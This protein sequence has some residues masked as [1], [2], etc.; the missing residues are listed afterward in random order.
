[1]I[2]RIDLSNPDLS[3]LSG[4]LKM[5]GR[6]PQGV[7]IYANNRY[8]TFGGRPWLPV[9]GEFHFSRFPNQ[10]WRDELLKM[11]AG[12]VQI[13]ASYLFWIHH[14]EIEGTFAWSGDFDYRRFIGLCA[15]LGMYVYPRIGPWAHGECRN[16][17]FPDWVL[18]KCGAGVRQDTQPYLSY[19]ERWYRQIARQ[20][21]G[22]LWK[23]GG[24]II[25]IQLE[26]ELIDNGPHILTLKRMAQD[27]GIDVP[28]YTMT[29][30]GPAQVPQDE[31]IPLFGGYPDAFWDRQVK[32]YARQSRFLYLFTPIRNDDMIGNDLL[33]RRDLDDLSYLDRYP[34][35][36]C[37]LGGGMQVSYHRRPFIT[38]GDAS[39]PPVC[40][41]GSG[42][43]LLGYYMYHG[44]SN[45]LGKLSTLQESQATHYWNDVPVISYDFQTVI[46]EYGQL[47]EQY[48]SLRLLHQFLHDFGSQLAPMPAAYPEQVPA[49]LDDRETLRWS[50]RS[51]GS[52][53]FVFINNYQR[54]ESL[55][56][57]TG[58]RLELKL[59]NETLTMPSAPFNLRSG[60]LMIW[61]FNLELGGLRL[62]YAT[63]QLVCRIDDQGT[64]CFVFAE[65]GGVRAEFALDSHGLAAVLGLEPAGSE[66]GMTLLRGLPYA[67]P[68]TLLDSQG[69]QVRI[70]LLSEEQSEQCWKAQIWGAE[71]L[72]LSSA[73][74]CFDGDSLHISAWRPEDLAFSVY[75]K[76]EKR[77]PVAGVPEGAFT[78]YTLSAAYKTVTVSTRKLSEGKPARVVPMGELGV[79]QAPDDSDFADAETWEVR[80]P[81]GDFD[82]VSDI[83]LQVDYV[84]DA[85]RAYLGDRLVADDFYYGRVWEIGLKRFAPEVLEKGL[86][87]KFLPLRLDAPVYIEAQ[88][89]PKVARVVLGRIWAEAKYEIEVKCL[90]HDAGRQP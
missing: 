13:V 47:N 49:S 56:S 54:V 48:H 35:A 34:Y 88:R 81:P 57:K 72:F 27:A 89:R 84:G 17:G 42:S 55:T 10:Y 28:L 6:N 44:G 8:L 65:R 85:A 82:G 62:R 80:L 70:L 21:G 4:H 41:L 15:E 86:T 31:V 7:E 46:R 2:H 74:L 75:P 39:A 37:E 33:P 23:E 43:N 83:F 58:V 45:P 1:M 71:R 79:A 29:G 24:P 3:V 9:M 73:G 87:L 38:P 52:I 12:G 30:W 64:A 68:V 36:T 59:K 16:G 11:K 76:P 60:A 53:G 5:G 25:G 66:A 32:T 20:L 61:P 51:D 22:M 50:A 19:V 18:E 26:N 63:A 67:H 77:L 14:E 69:G 40:K 90:D 78:R